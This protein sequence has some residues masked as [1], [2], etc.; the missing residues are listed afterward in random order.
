ME[1]GGE[2]RGAREQIAEKGRDEVGDGGVVELQLAGARLG[3]EVWPGL[4][5]VGL[6]EIGVSCV[7]RSRVAWHI[8][9][10]VDLDAAVRAEVLH[11]TQ[12]RDAPDL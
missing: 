1:E 8:D 6:D 7:D 5:V 4:A 10:K 3:G 2:G 12:V 9:F 11:L